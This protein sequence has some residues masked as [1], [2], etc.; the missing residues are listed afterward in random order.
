VAI[1][2][3]AGAISVSSPIESASAV[4]GSDF[5]PGNIITDA[6]F[7]DTTSMTASQVQSFLNSQV[8]SCSPG[9]TCLK[10]F[11]QAT[12]NKPATTQCAA[13]LGSANES[14]ATI[15]VRASQA[16]G[17]NPQVMLVTLQKEQAL[18]TSRSPSAWAL[19]HATG[20]GCPD[21]AACNPNFSGFFDQV[22]GAAAQ[23]SYYDKH[24]TSYRYQAHKV[25]NIQLNPNAG[26]GTQAVYIQNQA[27]ADLYIYTPY[28]PNTAALSNLYG[29]G[30]ACSAYGNRN[31]WRIYSDWFGNPAGPKLLNGSVDSA[32]GVLGGIQLTGWAVDP[33]APNSTYVWVNVD[34]TGGP[35]AAKEPLSWLAG[36]YP[37]LGI[38]HGY[39][40]VV[41]AAPGKH[42]VCVLQLSG[43]VLACK[44]VVVPAPG[45]AAGHVDSVTSSVGTISL[46][47]WSLDR[48]APN[49]GYLWVNVDGAGRSYP[50]DKI[51]SSTISTYPNS[52]TTT[53]FAVNIPATYGRH[54]VCA[55]GVGSVLLS[56]E[57]VSVPYAEDGQ[58]QSV[59]GVL[60]GATIAGWSLNQ[61]TPGTS[62]YVWVTVDGKGSAQRANLASPAAA[63]AAYPG[64]AFG[65]NHGFGATISAS[66]G[67]HSIC[68]WGTSENRSY[69]CKSVVVPNNEIG[70]V[71]SVTTDFSKITVTGWSLD[72]RTSASTYVWV[73]VDGSGSAA[74]ANKPLNWIDALYH[75]GANHG[76]SATVSATPG[77]H[78]V[79]VQGTSENVP[80]GCT[81]A[82]VPS[83]VTGSFDS[84]TGAAAVVGAPATTTSPA[85]SATPEGIQVKGWAV[86]R[87]ATTGMYVWIDVDGTG[88][89]IKA[90]KFLN[91][92]NGLY[93]GVGNNH[94]FD[95]LIPA[96]QGTHKVCAYVTQD[97]VS[98][99]CKTVTVP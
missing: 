58:F 16:C 75:R 1:L 53:G 72:Q 92:I 13:Y 70:N 64:A 65:T 48:T 76:F 81:T 32:Q 40:A 84:A 18:V 24:P 50:V 68:V 93:P 78:K 37:G 87:F 99:G 7:H 2:A 43:T 61:L 49:R 11:T 59:T 9:Y 95:S 6:N 15:I 54:Q 77:T 20:Y 33:Y 85:I 56:C 45:N 19:S 88:T 73:S 27:T 52:G 5:D 67:T 51:I 28:V 79:C 69:G 97:S 25:N 26:C 62:T 71:D 29:L 22:Y 74:A 4:T 39:D 30:D 14:A 34:G 83:P 66:P 60:G 41:P 38:N 21:T 89:A 80:Y 12:Y 90:D 10:S 42:S 35:I 8:S 36:M 44:T 17:L 47:G 94:G 82:T 3:V 31:F 63:T 86:N 55:Y 98:L 23:F 91:W 46:S 96:S 57:M